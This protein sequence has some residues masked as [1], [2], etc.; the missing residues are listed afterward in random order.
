MSSGT[1]PARNGIALR[2]TAGQILRVTNTH[3]QQVV[4][5]WAFSCEPHAKA[6]AA[7][8]RQRAQFAVEY[9]SMCH[10]RAALN[11]L[12]PSV[13]STLV[14]NHRRPILTLSKDTSPGIHDTL[15][16]ACDIYRYQGLIPDLG[17][18]YHDNCADNLHQALQDAAEEAQITTSIFQQ[19]QD[20]LQGFVPDPLNLFMNIPWLWGR[21][22]ELSFEPTVSKPGDYVEL[23]AEADVVVVMSA[24]PQDILTINSRKPADCHWEIVAS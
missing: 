9:M 22:G 7:T 16:A 23:T 13:G 19:I 15:I 3:G 21:A 4:D 17:E 1:I 14:S 5:T 10:T 20:R 12:R 24:C 11:A 18:N 2:L 6:S 8:G